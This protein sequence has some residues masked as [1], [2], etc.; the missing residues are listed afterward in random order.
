MA[1][2]EK[3]VY[4][5]VPA[6]PREGQSA[7][8]WAL[9]HLSGD[10]ATTIVVTHVHVPPQTIPIMGV[11]FHVSKMGGERVRQFRKVE[12]QKADEML[13]DYLRRCSEI[14]V[15]C[16]KLVIENEDV[17]SGLIEL[18]RLH[19]ITRLVVAAAADKHYSKK[20]VKPVSK[21]ATEITRRADPSCKIWF[22]CKDQLIYI[23]DKA[24]QIAQSASHQQEDDIQTEMV[25]YGELQKAKAY[26]DMYL[27]EVRK[28]EEL[29]AALARADGEIARLW[30]TFH[31]P[32]EGPE[33]GFDLVAT[34]WQGQPAEPW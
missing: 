31:R 2:E 13:D 6:E 29:E 32:T 18:I 1:E 22:V 4:V 30:R 24:V 8:S 21:T 23:R 28:R 17:V 14:K 27:E 19:G 12:R 10:G 15:K 34:A 9:G 7:L 26:E 5:A 20:L 11:K 3:K 33:T 16:E 25:L